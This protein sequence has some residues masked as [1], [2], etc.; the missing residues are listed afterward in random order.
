MPGLALENVY[1]VA[2]IAEAYHIL[3]D[4][5]LKVSR[6][7][8]GTLLN[9]PDVAVTWLS[10]NVWGGK[11]NPKG[12]GSIYGNVEFAFSWSKQITGRSFYWVE[13]MTGYTPPSYR[14]LLTHRDRSRGPNALTPYNPSLDNGPL[15]EQDGVWYYNRQC[16]SEFMIEAD[17]SLDECIECAIIPHNPRICHLNRKQCPES[18]ELV[19]G[20]LLAFI[21]A[22]RVHSVDH[23]LRRPPE[24]NA[25]WGL[26]SDMID[27]RGNIEAAMGKADAW[28]G[29]SVKK[30]GERRAVLRGAMALYA[31]GRIDDARALVAVLRSREIFVTA[32]DDVIDEHF[33]AE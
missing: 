31:A 21:L 17:V 3:E 29:G 26:C 13:A 12:K 19:A 11:R 16:T 28:Q 9:R 8:N 15:R 24:L 27:G 10:A 7:A 4:G 6:I 20:R 1:H 33:W 5:G 2:H 30:D 23:A 18:R 14:I 22:N 25:G 32:L